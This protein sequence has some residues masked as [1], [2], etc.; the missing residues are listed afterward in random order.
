MY[1]V[2]CVDAQD[3]DESYD[4]GLAAA[5]FREDE[6]E[7]P[8]QHEEKRVPSFPSVSQR[9]ACGDHAAYLYDEW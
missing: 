5:I 4:L 7:E 9:I 8:S 6:G 3:A 2:V 1:Y